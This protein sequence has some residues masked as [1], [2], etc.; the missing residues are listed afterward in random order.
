[1]TSTPRLDAMGIVVSDLRASLRFY[2]MLGLELPED[3]GD[4]QHVEATTPGGLRV[5]FDTI[6]V[7]RSFMPEWEPAS[8]GHRMGLAFHCGDAAGV[9]ATYARLTAAGYPGAKA[10]WD[11]FWGQRYA[12][13][14]DPDGNPVDL[15]APLD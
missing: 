7:V 6:A 12:Q 9:D 10:P 2:R 3:P 13:V 8:G 11:A 1:M 4:E 14:S 15:F 5:M